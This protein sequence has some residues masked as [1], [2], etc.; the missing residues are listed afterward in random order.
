M[1]ASACP[2]GKLLNEFHRSLL[3]G[4][5]DFSFFLI[6][7]YVNRLKMI[8]IIKKEYHRFSS[9]NNKRLLTNI[10]S[11][12]RYLAF[13]FSSICLVCTDELLAALH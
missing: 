3:I 1:L 2:N 4:F 10:I 11:L 6:N 7:F 5:L 9:I 8:I 12:S 13:S